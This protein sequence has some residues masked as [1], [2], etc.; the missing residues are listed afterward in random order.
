[1][2]AAPTSRDRVVDALVEVWEST[3]RLL[4]ALGDDD[5]ARPSPLP[6]WTVHDVVSHI[7][8]T[9]AMLLGEPT[10]PIY[11]DRTQA[12]HVRRDEDL[13]NERWVQSLRSAP[14][15]A[16]RR[17]FERRTAQR[18]T[19]LRSM[20][21][22]EW[23]TASFAPVSQFS[24][25]EVMHI[26]VYDCWIHEQDIRDA[27]NRPGNETGL[28]VDVTLDVMNVT[29]GPAVAP[30]LVGSE[31]TVTYRLTSGETVVRAVHLYLGDPARVVR[32]LRR[33]AVATLTMP[34][35]TMTRLS[36]G[37]IDPTRAG[38]QIRLDGDTELAAH[39]LESQSLLWSL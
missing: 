33:P 22:R 10:P 30:H 20:T 23:E 34:V 25:E 17:L 8:G 11:V 7:V 2:G 4:N 18:I 31:K 35:G 38:A 21:D 19:S 37:R 26:R 1:M 13:D 12:P 28:A 24:Y 3:R 32:S 16:L 5:W 36:S 15:A 27:T 9:E 39:L 6:G 29:L 14:P